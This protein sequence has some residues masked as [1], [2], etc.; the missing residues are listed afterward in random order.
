MKFNF[1]VFKANKGN[2]RAAYLHNNQ[3]H[4]VI[5]VDIEAENGNYAYRKLYEMYPEIKTNWEIRLTN[6]G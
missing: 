6:I 4:I 3:K 1:K 2:S 5:D